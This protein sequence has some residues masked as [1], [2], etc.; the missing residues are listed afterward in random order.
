[1]KH[2]LYF[3]CLLC[4]CLPLLGSDCSESISNVV[5]GTQLVVISLGDSYASGEG[6]PDGTT[7]DGM[8]R[9]LLNSDVDSDPCH[10]SFNNSHHIAM[11]TIEVLWKEKW[12]FD[13]ESQSVV[14]RNFA[15]AGATID[16]G[17]ISPQF[18]QPVPCLQT[19]PEVYNSFS[20]VDA[21]EEWL[22]SETS[23]ERIDVVLLS[24][25]GN[26]VGF[27]DIVSNGLK[28]FLPPPPAFPNG[29]MTND[30]LSNLVRNGEY[31]DGITRRAV[32]LRQLSEHLTRAVAEIKERLN[33]KW[34]VI[35]GYP[36]GVRNAQGIVCNKWND[37]FYVGTDMMQC[38]V[39]YSIPIGASAKE[40]TDDEN[41]WGLLNVLFPLNDTLERVAW[42]NS[43]VVFVDTEN[44]LLSHPYCDSHRWINSLEDS[45][46]KQG[47]VNGAMHPNREGHEA[48]AHRIVKELSE[49]LD[50]PEGS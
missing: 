17:L 47:D 13:D 41:G 31:P 14:Y 1:M 38:V 42:A 12:G 29:V 50:L 21:A 39:P 16:S 36:D 34:I 35:V 37:D 32:G 46:N 19:S 45:F 30:Q 49:L 33:P 3:L 48:V 10:R 40:V 11:E 25:G 18:L 9:W 2:Y 20:Q 8:G 27:A 15:C 5:E 7:S 43:E 22:N 28:P 26:D 44:A 4:L 24:I 23:V 6:N